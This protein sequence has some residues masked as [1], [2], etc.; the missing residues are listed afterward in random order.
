MLYVLHSPAL[1]RVKIGIARDYAKRLKQLTRAYG[2]LVEVRAFYDGVPGFEDKRLEAALHWYYACHRI[3]RPGCLEERLTGDTEWFGEAV[4]DSIR[5]LAPKPV[6]KAYKNTRHFE[7]RLD[8]DDVETLKRAGLTVA[9]AVRKAAAELREP[10]APAPVPTRPEPSGAS[11][12][13]L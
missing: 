11:G 2:E 1:R 10:V 8:R 7:M 5:D 9:D 4:L 3:A 6:L 12:S 13:R